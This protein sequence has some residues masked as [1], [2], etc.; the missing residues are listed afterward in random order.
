MPPKRLV[1]F[2]KLKMMEHVRQP[3]HM[4]V[5]QELERESIKSQLNNVNDL[6]NIM[7]QKVSCLST[8]DS[9]KT[10]LILCALH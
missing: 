6:F 4:G 5:I 1:V 7:F 8:V 2:L 10:G 9:V 3:K